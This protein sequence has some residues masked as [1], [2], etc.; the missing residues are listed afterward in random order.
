MPSLP[1]VPKPQ[2]H[3][4][5]WVRGKR[6]MTLCRYQLLGIP[7]RMAPFF[8]EKKDCFPICRYK[9][10]FPMRSRTWQK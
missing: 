6:A 7:S 4:R 8:G 1:A 2:I 10:G 3:G 9:R 5:I